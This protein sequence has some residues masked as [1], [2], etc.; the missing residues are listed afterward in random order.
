MV[1]EK[2]VEMQV[3]TEKERGLWAQLSLAEKKKLCEA[4]G[5][6]EGAARPHKPKQY[7]GEGWW[8]VPEP[9]LCSTFHL[10]ITIIII[11]V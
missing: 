11:V 7:T 2:S 1:Q 6:V 9:I 10:T 4:I 3:R 5:Y 8:P